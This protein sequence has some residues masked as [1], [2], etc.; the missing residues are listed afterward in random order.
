MYRVVDPESSRK[1]ARQFS[2]YNENLISPKNVSYQLR[3]NEDIK[4]Q[5][6]CTL[7]TVIT[8]LTTLEKNVKA[9][10]NEKLEGKR[11]DQEYAPVTLTR[12]V[13]SF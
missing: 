4:C 8:S 5:C 1:K 12:N 6:E 7:I 11:T 3:Y 2:N 13:F 9:F 10:F